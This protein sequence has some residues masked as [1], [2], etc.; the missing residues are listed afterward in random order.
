MPNKLFMEMFLVC[1]LETNC[2]A[3]E[4]VAYGSAWKF[5]TYEHNSTYPGGDACMQKKKL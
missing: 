2:A 1:K 5:S 3:S 4:E